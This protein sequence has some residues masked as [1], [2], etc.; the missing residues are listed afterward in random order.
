MSEPS[1]NN[2]DLFTK[3]FLK[4][5]IDE[6]NI[7]LKKKGYFAFPKA[8]NSNVIS[9]IHQDATKNRINLNN[10]EITGVYAE[11][12]YYLINLLSVSKTF[13]DF[14]TSKIVFDICK[15]F[16]GNQFRLKAL[17]YYETYGKH[18]MQWHTDNKIGRKFAHI[19]GI[20]FIFYISDVEE[21]QFQYIEGSHLWSGEKEYSDYSNDFIQKNYK[22]KIKDF[23]FPSGSL[24]IYNT[25]GIH[26]AKPVSNKK[27]I[28]KSVFFQ[29]DSEVENSE[30]IIL[31]SKFIRNVDNDL[32]MFLGFGKKS[33]YEVFPKTSINDLSFNKTTRIYLKYIFFRFLENLKIMLPKKIKTILKK[34]F[35]KFKKEELN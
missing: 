27:F 8:I 4:T 9:N 10:N 11:K 35:K 30:P 1:L 16:L 2:L 20:I 31:N 17:R 28:R 33:S 21:G 24:I 22:E 6:I 25:Y 12:Q 23:K 32:K 26:R 13:Y 18:L 34:Y 29:V 19:P 15:K 7:E 5:N 3:E 14:V